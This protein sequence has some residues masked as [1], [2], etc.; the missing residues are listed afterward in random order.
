[1]TLIKTLDKVLVP[2]FYEYQTGN[3][4]KIHLIKN[5][6]KL[7]IKKLIGVPLFLSEE[8]VLVR[9]KNYWYYFN[10][11]N[12]CPALHVVNVQKFYK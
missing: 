9:E 3:V 6:E 12:E 11:Y 2:D 4:W 7:P 8:Q 10:E 5:L 1:M